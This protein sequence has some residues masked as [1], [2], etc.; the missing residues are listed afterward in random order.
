MSSYL[1]YVESFI[2]GFL[3]ACAALILQVFLSVLVEISGHELSLPYAALH[4]FFG[5]ALFFLI[6]AT[7]EE[8]LR[9]FIIKKRVLT[10]TKDSLRSI[11][12]HG[13]LIGCGFWLFEIILGFIKD[14]TIF[15]HPFSV[16]SVL[17]IH[18][19]TSVLLLFLLKKDHVLYSILAL[20]AVITIH[21]IGNLILFFATF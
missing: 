2:L 14:P 8:I 18:V 6:I 4:Y 7:I 20:I 15:S 17:L 21:T 16:I 5:V 1:H 19:L 12:A 9:F 3:I 10:Y 11:L 13:S